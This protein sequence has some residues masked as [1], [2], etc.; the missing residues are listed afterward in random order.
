MISQTAENYLAVYKNILYSRIRF[1]FLDSF[2]FLSTSLN[3]LVGLLDKK[4]DFK[5]LKQNYGEKNL[6]LLMQKSFF[7]YS[8]IS[9][10]EKLAETSLPEKKDFYND[11]MMNI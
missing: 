2:R 4:K 3:T 10:V 8:Y 5:I 7:P 11:L 6:D 1:V 9:S